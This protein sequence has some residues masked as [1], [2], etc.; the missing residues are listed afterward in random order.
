MI[1]LLPLLLM[2][3]EPALDCDNAMTQMAMNHCAHLDYEAADAALNAQWKITA[4]TM[5]QRDENFDS[6]RDTRSGYFETLLEAQR[7]WLAYRDAHCQSE[8]YYARGG[9]LEPMLVSSC[10]AQLTRERTSQL[11]ELVETY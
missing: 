9:S 2:A 7:A 8:G 4:A 5:K 3:S 6:D 10:L 11:A 1:A